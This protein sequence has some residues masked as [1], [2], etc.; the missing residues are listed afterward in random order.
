MEERTAAMLALLEDARST[1]EEPW[2][3]MHAGGHG[4]HWS[5]ALR[6]V[7]EHRRVWARAIER[8]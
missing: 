8:G 3:S 6:Y 2:A 1:G 4:D 7:R 5:S